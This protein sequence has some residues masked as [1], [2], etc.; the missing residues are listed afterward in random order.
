MYSV[1]DI[2]A[3]FLKFFE[4][5]GHRVISS[6]P[7]VPHN[8]PTLMFTNAGM[9]PFKDIFTGNETRDYKRATTAQKC[10]R[11]GGKHNDLDNV[12]YTAR[13]HTFFEMM[14]NFSFSD[15][16][17][18]EAIYYAYNLLTKDFALP[19][20]KLLITVYH[21]DD[22]AFNLWK[23]IAGFNDDKII[24]IKGSDN[25]WMM[26]DTGPC[27][28]CS[29]IFYDHGAE[30]FGGP[31]GSKDQDGDRFI[32]I[33]NLVFMQYE[34]LSDGT[35]VKL[36][37]PSIDTGMGLERM[38]AVLQHVHNNYDI[39]L[40]KNIIKTTE[41]ISKI[42]AD[43]NINS[44]RVIA[45]HIRS[46]SF[47]L[48]DGV[49]PSN[50]GRGYVLRRIMRRAMRH[51]KQIG[52]KDSLMYKL[53][54]S[55][56]KEM[57]EA[58]PELNRASGL[59]TEILKL[60]EENFSD[61][62]DRGLKLLDKE[63][64]NLNKGGI[65]SGD[66]AFK[67]YDTYGFPY[68]LTVDILRARSIEVDEEGFKQAMSL[69]K[70][71]ARAAWKG[72]GEKKSEEI[73]YKIKEEHGA[74]EFLGYETCEAQG[75]VLAIVKDGE[76]VA[77]ANKDDKIYIV[78]NQTS[79]Y[80]ESG[81]QEGDHGTIKGKNFEARI[82]NT[83]KHLGS[84]HV[85]EA[86]IISGSIKT[87]EI[88]TTI[89]DKIRRD[90]LRSNHSATHIL[91]A[92]LR[93]VL[94]E[95]VTQKGS[96]VAEDYLRFDISHPKALSAQEKILVEDKVNN[97]IRQN[98]QVQTHIMKQEEAIKSG[99]L[100]LFGEKYSD[101]VRVLSMG[102]KI[103]DKSYSTELCGGTHVNYTGDIGLFKIISEGAIASGVRR[104]EAVTGDRAVKLTQEIEKKLMDA[105]A[106]LKISPDQLNDRLENLIKER[107]EFEQELNNLRKATMFSGENSDV[108]PENINGVNFIS[109]I[110]KEAS[111]QDLREYA[112]ETLKKNNDA[113]IVLASSFENKASVIIA[114]SDS[115]TN[116]LNAANF[117][118]EVAPI[119]GAKGGGGKP[120]F[121]QTG[122]T[123]IEA[124]AEAIAK[125]RELLAL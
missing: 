105:A 9:V 98:S 122:G 119:V 61:T 44:F 37:A 12:G 41:D 113:I 36:P 45:D 104:I 2:R 17:K 24:R 72:S 70:Q 52:Y 55:L 28:P 69:Q 107:K 83:V 6:A 51:V 40:F 63:T 21:D 95:H 92:V 7:L 8:D 76:L 20:D 91:H 54:P 112:L 108:A 67:L 81:G 101:E 120:N 33:W 27:G 19:K 29:E 5:N 58:Y 38:A 53:V 106:K 71:R 42:S 90:K 23:K 84:L 73:W 43:K 86:E 121:A 78:L 57:G 89:V 79:F 26:G 97:V 125:V 80:A 56:I 59:I 111:P 62:L 4:N 10:V 117:I 3:I 65:L 14:G 34:S 22:E 123:N 46:S 116:K 35:K 64:E 47:L 11:A 103:V 39:D 96:L 13:H 118:K 114:L 100:A 85:H 25:F 94:G 93:E 109:R 74:T 77:S 49:M 48:A 30:I 75:Q 87:G 124:L 68:D 15:Y 88:I 82:L 110:F 102:E 1:N 32:E 50:E 18:E 115:L 16:F 31:P 99:A 66:I 60:E